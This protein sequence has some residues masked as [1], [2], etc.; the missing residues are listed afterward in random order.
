MK[1]EGDDATV[2]WG[3]TGETEFLGEVTIKFAWEKKIGELL[4]GKAVE[5]TLPILQPK[6]VDRAWGQIVVAK[7]ETLDVRPAG[8][9]EGLRPI[10]P[11]HDLM[12]GASV[13]DAARAWEFYDDWKL[14]LS[15]TRYELVEVKRGSIERAVIRMEVTR[16][17]VVSVQ[18]LYRLRS[19]QQR[20]PL[21]LPAKVSF[22]TDPLRINGR[23]VALESEEPTAGP[24]G[25]PGAATA[26]EGAGIAP[27]A[28]ERAGAAAG[29]PA[30]APAAGGREYFIPLAGHNA[31]EPLVIELRY[32]MP[33]N[34]HRLD[35]PVFPSNPAVQK[36][37]LCG[38]VPQE[39]K[40][41]GSRGPWTD[42]MSWN[43]YETLSGLPQ[44][45][46]RDDQ[47]V[48]WVIEGLNV[49]NPFQD[50][51][52]D[53]LLHTFSTLQPA[54]PPGGSLRLV[55]VH[56]HVLHALVFVLVLAV[57]LLTI[58][59]PLP[60]KFAIVVL[61]VM[62]LL[63]VGVFAPA[64]ARQIMDGALLTAILIVAAAWL[65]WH[66]AR[67]W[68]L[69]AAAWAR[70]R[71]ARAAAPPSPPAT[72]PPAASSPAPADASPAPAE[73]GSPFSTQEGGPTHE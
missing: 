72:P 11:Q 9:P 38:Y 4:V 5:E 25:D 33:G 27:A 19:V 66:I 71:A 52:T 3:L 36:V 56:K 34:Y 20:L 73:A 40:V 49:P 42:E 65:A 50:F 70:R 46:Q 63:A 22:D 1:K 67:A 69:L 55:A 12:P 41:L 37:Y 2:A 32:T 47:L 31:D 53:G 59:R 23:S 54:E 61:L 43:W 7:A 39:L 6:N 64:F 13:A 26:A 57:G 24:G 15:I 48:A 16:S 21:R 60:Q 68:S 45:I 30:A 35:L 18:A 10:D 29:A 58:R 44:P 14:K 8:D 17:N 51:A 62:F 28:E